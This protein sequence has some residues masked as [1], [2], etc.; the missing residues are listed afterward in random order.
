MENGLEI[1][2]ADLRTPVRSLALIAHMRN[3]GISDQVD[4]KIEKCM[5]SVDI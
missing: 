3:N 5:N 2:R 1:V 4:R